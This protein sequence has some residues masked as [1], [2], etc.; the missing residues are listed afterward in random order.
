MSKQEQSIDKIRHS[1]SHIMAM[2]V[3]KSFPKAKIAIGPMIENGFYYD[4]DVEGLKEE[5]LPEI[6]WEMKKIIKSGISFEKSEMSFAD[7]RRFF[8]KQPYK[9]ELIDELENNGEKNVSIYKSGDFTDL[10]KGPHVDSEKDL[11]G[12]A[13]KLDKLAGAYWRGSEKNKMLTRIYALAFTSAEDLNHFLNLR[14]EA[15]KRDHRVI[16]KEYF[17]FDPV[18]GLG[19]AMW[20]PKGALLW[21]IIEDFWYKKHLDSGYDLVRS[22]H[23]GSRILWETSGH[24][25]FYNDSMYPVLEVGRSLKDYQD[26]DHVAEKNK[27]EYLLKPMNCPF[28]V[29]IYKSEPHSYRD[30]P[31]RW[32][33]CGTVYRYEKSGELSGLTRVRG[34]TQDDAHIIC[35][36]D[37]IEEELKMV[38]MFI[39]E[40]FEAFGF[41]D[42]KVYLSV[43]DPN[44][45]EKYA[46]NDEGWKFTEEILEKVA[47][48]LKLDYIK[49]EGEA[50]F[51][52]PKLDYKIK[53]VLGREW[54]CSTLQFDF[55][56]PERF[57]MT[58]VNSE[59]KE[60]RPYMLHRALMG[61]FERFMGLLIENYAGAFPVWL[62]PV[63]IKIVSVGSAHVDFCEQ[64]AGE[65]KALGIRVEV[66]DLNE[67][68]GN[69]IRKA[70]GEKVPYM[71][72]IGDKEI[73]SDKLQVRVRGQKDVVEYS[74]DEFKKM[75]L[76]KI[77]TRDKELK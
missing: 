27:E 8:E 36:K 60:E 42:Y 24:W 69:K 68:V 70:T 46:G 58:F 1:L 62:S 30:L 2:A 20:K 28:H 10:C 52:G 9:L 13:F 19:L 35:R 73:A 37:Q 48:D 50:A 67:T 21:R 29:K 22:P 38:A 39:R 40:Y 4:F 63:Q 26:N 18:V 65:F 41:Y 72:V 6:E 3:L 75:I 12:V 11:A 32:A 5:M 17:L 74:K 55:N 25:N 7:A 77:V 66:D 64:L 43:R 53:D 16:G 61:S 31:C 49:E 23:I 57:D 33:E 47:K 76:G 44:N 56:L 15:E 59:G 54:Q 34:F 71:L 45:K 14:A 51:Y